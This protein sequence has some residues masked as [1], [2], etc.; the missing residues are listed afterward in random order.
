MGMFVIVH[1]A[2][3]EHGRR[4][5]R[6]LR[7]LRRVLDHWPHVDGRRAHARQKLIG[8]RCG[9]R[10]GFAL[11]RQQASRQRSEFGHG[12]ASLISC[13]RYETARR[14]KMGTSR[15]RLLTLR[16]DDGATTVSLASVGTKSRRK[17]R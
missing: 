10:L 14:P 17:R 9:R 1:R 4:E 15:P 2:A 13:V 3:A 11:T 8:K 6:G 5:M 7:T 12:S 16:K